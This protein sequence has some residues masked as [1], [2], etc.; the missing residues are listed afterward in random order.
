MRVT[1]ISQRYPRFT[2]VPSPPNWALT[3]RGTFWRGHSYTITGTIRWKI[4]GYQT[5]SM[6]FRSYFILAVLLEPFRYSRIV[7][8]YTWKLPTIAMLRQSIFLYAAN[9]RIWRCSFR[10]GIKSW[11][12]KVSM[13]G[14]Y[15]ASFRFG[16]PCIRMNRIHRMHSDHARFDLLPCETYTKPSAVWLLSSIM[17]LQ[18]LV[19]IHTRTKL[20]I[21]LGTILPFPSHN[22][23]RVFTARWML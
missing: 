10:V 20:H 19:L 4:S 22:A 23:V 18:S 11:L 7:Y 6:L 2:A 15:A 17:S 8:K 21:R 16:L 9:L 14:S 13:R 12:C 3:A 1:P 5:Y